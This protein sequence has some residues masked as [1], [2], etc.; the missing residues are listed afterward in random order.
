MENA[1]NKEIKKKKESANGKLPEK[2]FVARNSLLTDLFEISHIQTIYHIFIAILL[3]LFM[4][5]IIED[6]VDKGRFDLDFSLISWAFGN[7]QAVLMTW[8]SISQSFVLIVSLIR[9]VF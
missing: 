7:M 9:L 3:L 4:S 1:Y 8:V 6:V 5:T 2:E